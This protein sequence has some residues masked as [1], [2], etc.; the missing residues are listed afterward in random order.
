MAVMTAQALELSTDQ[1]ADFS[2]LQQADSLAVPSISAVAEH[3]ILVGDN[4]MFKPLT[5]VSREMAAAVAVRV[6]AMK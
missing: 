1:T 5:L 2:D 3:G 6:Y 4:G